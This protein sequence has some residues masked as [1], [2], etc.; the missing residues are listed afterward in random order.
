[1]R[2]GKI[3]IHSP[4][5]MK[6]PVWWRRMHIRIAQHV[7]VAEPTTGP[8]IR[9]AG[10]KTQEKEMTSQGPGPCGGRA[11]EQVGLGVRTKSTPLHIAPPAPAPSQSPEWWGRGRGKKEKDRNEGPHLKQSCSYEQVRLSG[12]LMLVRGFVS[13][14]F[15]EAVHNG[16]DGEADMDTSA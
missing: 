8:G 3:K 9:K 16:G 11:A 6:L 1:M 13:L 10:T 15:G 7:T 12:T 14:R 5:F 2:I 4:P